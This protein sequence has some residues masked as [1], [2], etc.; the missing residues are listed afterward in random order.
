[1][2]TEESSTAFRYA[3]FWRRLN[4]YSIDAMIVVVLTA[5]PDMLFG[6]S[7]MAQTAEDIETLKQ[8][9]LI[10]ESGDSQELLQ[11]LIAQSGGTASLNGMLENFAYDITLAVII[12]ALY[13]IGFVASRWQATPGKY[14][15]G[16]KVVM[17]DGSPLTLVQSAYRHVMSGVSM[18]ILGGMGYITMAFSPEK[19]ALHDM[20]C[21]TRVMRVAKG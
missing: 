9:G 21:N 2:D 20:I 4:A 8:M 17:R 5:L 10:P 12:S 1:M 7:A 18:V 16:M 11:T 13:N 6:G 3:G 19:A 15:L 14:W